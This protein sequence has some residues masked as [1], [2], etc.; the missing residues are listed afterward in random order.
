MSDCKIV[1]LDDHLARLEHGSLALFPSS[2]SEDLSIRLRENLAEFLSEMPS[3]Q[4]IR[5]RCTLFG[6]NS[7]SILIS[8]L[9][10]SLA[11]YQKPK[12]LCTIELPLRSGVEQNL[13]VGASYF[14]RHFQLTRVQNDGYDDF[15]AMEKECI[16]EAS[17]SNIFFVSGKEL[18]T[19]S[20]DM[21]ILNGVAR[22]NIIRFW[23]EE[24]FDVRERVVK[25]DEVGEYKHCFLC[26]SLYP[27]MPVESISLLGRKCSYTFEMIPSAFKEQ[28]E[29]LWRD[30]SSGV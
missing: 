18:I 16:I 12:L 5:G 19:P 27:A 15:L 2:W 9:P 24:G 17:R 25:I 10:F 20:L 6:N 22:R 3:G 28:L 4:L 8:R 7:I 13:K 1:F 30:N 29:K 14:A 11:A 26:N 23:K 21:G